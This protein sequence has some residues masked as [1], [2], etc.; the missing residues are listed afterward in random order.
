MIDEF[1]LNGNYIKRYSRP[2]NKHLLILL[3]GQSMGPR[4]FWDF[5]LPNGKTHS[6]YFFEAGIDVILFDPIGYGKSTEFYSYDRKGYASQIINLTKAIDKEYTNKT[7]LGFSTSTNPALIAAQSGYF[8]KLVCLSPAIFRVV[9]ENFLKY[10]EVFTSDINKLKEERIGKISD[11]IIPKPNRVD[12]WEEAIMEVNK[13]YTSYK[14]GFWSCPGSMVN[15]INSFYTIHKHDGYSPDSIKCDVLAIIGQYDF[16]MY[17]SVNFTWFV[18]TFKPKFV[19]VPDSTHFNMWENNNH[20]TRQA[21]ID[22]ITNETEV[23]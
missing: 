14:D 5:R 15:D 9:D 21:I 13:T 12:G 4:S 23:H 22:F 19:N 3:S 2:E 6:E 20:I 17:N 7:L 16:E 18:R 1:V 10:D 8:T 11:M